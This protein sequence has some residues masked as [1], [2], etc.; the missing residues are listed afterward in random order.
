MTTQQQQTIER[1]KAI[2][3]KYDKKYNEVQIDC[4]EHPGRHTA[5]L[6]KHGHSSEPA[7]IWECPL[8]ASDSHDCQDFYDDTATSDHMGFQGHY[9]TE[10][11]IKVCEVCEVTLDD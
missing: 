8:G 4:P 2:S 7:G 10:T 1:N 6:Y 5:T 11:A 9:Q 3:S